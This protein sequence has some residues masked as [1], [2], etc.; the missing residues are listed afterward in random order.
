VPAADRRRPGDDAT[1][2]SSDQTARAIRE[3]WEVLLPGALVG[4]DDDFFHLGG[5]SLLA[6]QMLVMVEQATGVTVPMGELLHA[7]TVRSLAEVVR[8]ASADGDASQRSTVACVQAG[9]EEHRPRLWFVH[10][11]QGSAYRVRHVARELGEDQPVWSFESPLLRGGPSSSATLQEFVGRYVADLRAEQPQGPYWL[12]GYSFGGICAYEMARQLRHAGEEVAFTAVI[13]VGPGYRGPGWGGRRAPFRPWFGVAKPPPPGASRREAFDHYRRLVRESPR[14]ALR[15]LMVR[16]GIAE[17]VDPFRFRADL[18]RHG[19]VRP[20]WRLWYA[21]NEH[22]RLAATAWD[23]GSRYDGRV[24]L[25]WADETPSD[26]ASLGWAPLVADLEI[27]RFRG[28]HEGILEPRGAGSLAAAL[29][30]VLDDALRR[31]ASDD[32]AG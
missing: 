30:P 7:R 19:R 6:A 4:P 25:F 16:T 29:R 11:L 18:R 22:W 20:E 26:D 3:V 2:M 10:D 12:A 24:D 8:R 9:D 28:D 14:R 13:D 15:H 32:G 1:P 31:R 27:H 21:W 23:R 17:R 5:D